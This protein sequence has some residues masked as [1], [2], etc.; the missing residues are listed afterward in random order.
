M[1]RMQ[2]SPAMMSSLW[3]SLQCAL[4]TEILMLLAAKIESLLSFGLT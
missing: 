4:A 2:R 1:M 3:P